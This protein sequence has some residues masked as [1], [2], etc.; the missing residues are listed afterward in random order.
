MSLADKFRSLRSLEFRKTPGNY[1]IGERDLNS[2][3]EYNKGS[4]KIVADSRFIESYISQIEPHIETGDYEKVSFDSAKLN[5]LYHQAKNSQV[6][7]HPGSFDVGYSVDY[8]F[9]VALGK[10]ANSGPGLVD[11]QELLQAVNRI[12]R[13]R[14]AMYHSGSAKMMKDGAIEWEQVIEE[15]GE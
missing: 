5:S 11:N 2:F 9:G 8:S 6:H 15:L 14:P 1:Q 13:Y 7:D 3:S 10:A 4:A 12:H